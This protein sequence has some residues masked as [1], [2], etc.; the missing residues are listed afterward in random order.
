[1]SNLFF[2]DGNIGAG[3]ST[4]LDFVEEHGQGI[5]GPS[6]KVIVI[7]EP[8]DL[9]SM[10]LIGDESIL[11]LYYQDKE[12]Y[13]FMFQANVIMTRIFQILKI[14]QENPDALIIAERSPR[15]G[16]IF[17]R[18][19][20]AEGFLKEEEY[21]LHLQWILMSEELLKP[22]GLIYIKVSPAK[23]MERIKM[24]ARPCEEGID[25]S[26]LEELHELHEGY[27]TSSLGEVIVIDGEPDGGVMSQVEF[28]FLSGLSRRILQ[29]IQ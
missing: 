20:L 21:K 14:V 25:E 16:D 10:P 7:K 27:V 15:S 11:A 18:Q 4:F 3:K 28:L 29:K 9:W 8:V 2:V 26:F 1:M 13:A 24:R 19:L 17:A 5:I 22:Q 6:P 12:K 23:C